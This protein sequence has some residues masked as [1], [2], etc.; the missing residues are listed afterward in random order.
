[1]LLAGRFCAAS[2]K[3]A[4]G[5]FLGQLLFFFFLFFFF[6]FFLIFVF[7]E[8][9]E[10]VGVEGGAG[11]GEVEAFG[12]GFDGADDGGGVRFGVEAAGVVAG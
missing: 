1:L 4:V 8:V 3:E 5:L 11:L 12:G 9:V 2:F 6:H 10:V 7:V